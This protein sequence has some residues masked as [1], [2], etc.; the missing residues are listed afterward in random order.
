MAYDGG[1][2]CV[3]DAESNLEGVQI[4]FGGLTGDTPAVRP[5]ASRR[6]DRRQNCGQ[7]GGGDKS[8]RQI[9]AV[10]SID[11]Y[12]SDRRFPGVRWWIRCREH[13]G[14]R[15]N[16]KQDEYTNVCSTDIRCIAWTLH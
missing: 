16:E 8:W 12:R 10:R 1:I 11:L 7:S 14:F 13:E 6:S 9:S 3:W 2:V 15:R 5:S 4:W